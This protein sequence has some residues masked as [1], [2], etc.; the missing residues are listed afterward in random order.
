MVIFRCLWISL[1]CRWLLENRVRCSTRTATP[2]ETSRWSL[3]SL[4]P[5][6]G[7]VGALAVEPMIGASVAGWAAGLTLAEWMS[8]TARRPRLSVLKLDM[9]NR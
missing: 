5:G 4:T 3:W 7:Y 2:E 6:P 8:L 9:S 1:T